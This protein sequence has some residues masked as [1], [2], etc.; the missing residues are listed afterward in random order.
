[1]MV[2]NLYYIVEF[3]DEGTV[4]FVPSVWMKDLSHV[5]W[6]T[7]HIKSRR[8]QRETPIDDVY[9]L[10]SVR[11]LGTAGKLLHYLKSKK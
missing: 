3:V 11:V 8:K 5:L 2:D 1:M 9:K 6:P 7:L 4:D 10:Y